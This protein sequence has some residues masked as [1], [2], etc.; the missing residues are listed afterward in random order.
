[1]I[2]GCTLE[3]PEKIVYIDELDE[4]DNVYLRMVRSKILRSRMPRK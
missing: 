2:G 3:V 4:D 1:L